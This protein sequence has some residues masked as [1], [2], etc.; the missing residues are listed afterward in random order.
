MGYCSA[1]QLGGNS[2]R[3][4]CAEQ[5]MEPECNDEIIFKYHIERN[6]RIRELNATLDLNDNTKDT[7]IKFRKYS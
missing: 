6:K 5:V 1:G 7:I 2:H 4:S 3:H